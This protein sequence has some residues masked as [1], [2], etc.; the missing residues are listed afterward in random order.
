M[1][2]AFDDPRHRRVDELTLD[3]E[4]AEREGRSSR[5]LWREAA[6]LETELALSIPIAKPKTRG[7]LTASAVG[8]WRRSGERALALDSLALFRED[9]ELSVEVRRVVEAGLEWARDHGSSLTERRA[10]L[11]APHIVRVNQKKAA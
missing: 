4:L 7:A 1:T 8:L 11:R 3:A 2:S 6:E 9:A 10:R 5:A